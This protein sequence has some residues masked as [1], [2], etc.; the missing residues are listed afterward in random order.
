MLLSAAEVSI[1]QAAEDDT[2]RRRNRARLWAPPKGYRPPPGK[3]VRVPGMGM[4]AAQA[5]AMTAAAAAEDARL[6]AG[7]R[8]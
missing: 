1:D 4:T 6:T 8:G 2:E 3:R 5:R 7:R